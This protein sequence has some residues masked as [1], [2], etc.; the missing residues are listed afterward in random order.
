MQYI[1]VK[2]L[3][4]DSDQPVCLYHELN[5]ARYEQRKV[6]EY[7]DGTLHSAD[8]N[9]NQGSTFLAWEPFPT[10]EEI[11]SEPEFQLSI[12]TALEFERIWQQATSRELERV[13]AR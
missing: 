2:W 8:A 12:I 11:C 7:R 10:N 5:D 9:H 6:E 13:A 3:H 4:E 1:A